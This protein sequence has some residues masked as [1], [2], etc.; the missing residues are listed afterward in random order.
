MTLMMYTEEISET[1]VLTTDSA[2]RPH[3]YSILFMVYLTML[4]VFQNIQRQ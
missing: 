1:L 3:V 4:S 2:D